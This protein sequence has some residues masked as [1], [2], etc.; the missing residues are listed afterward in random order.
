MTR[1]LN[2]VNSPYISTPL[3][4]RRGAR[5]TP[6]TI[7]PDIHHY[8]TPTPVRRGVTCG[9]EETTCSPSSPVAQWSAKS[10]VEV[11]QRANSSNRQAIALSLRRSEYVSVDGEEGVSRERVGSEV[12]VEVRSECTEYKSGVAK[13]VQLC[14]VSSESE[15]VVRTADSVLKSPARRRK[16]CLTH[17]PDYRAVK[18]EN[19][20]FTSSRLQQH[21]SS[22]RLPVF[23]AHSHFTFHTSHISHF[24]H[25][26]FSTFHIL[27]FSLF[28]L[29]LQFSIFFIILDSTSSYFNPKVVTVSQIKFQ[30]IRVYCIN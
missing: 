6:L 30:K 1:D 13:R 28:T 10:Q 23:T 20:D 24:L 4:V 19:N 18:C 2:N 21:V 27:H 3:S 26:T 25:F 11:R 17:V 29:H 9:W 14:D 16:V 7:H 8:A 12:R 15:L 22:A 5:D